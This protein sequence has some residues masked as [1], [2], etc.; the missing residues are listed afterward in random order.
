MIIK[1][2]NSKYPTI[3]SGLKVHTF[4]SNEQ[5]IVKNCVDKFK[6]IWSMDK[7]FLNTSSRAQ[8]HSTDSACIYVAERE[9]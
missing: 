2:Q 1:I 8:K 7:Y 5:N 9:N 3:K 6:T 4:F